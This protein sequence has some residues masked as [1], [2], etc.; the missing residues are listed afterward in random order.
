M[1]LE[2]RRLRAYHPVPMRNVEV[3]V[4]YTVVEIEKSNR[5]PPIIGEVMASRWL[6]GWRIRCVRTDGFTATLSTSDSWWQP[7]RRLGD[8]AVIHVDLTP[9]AS[10]E[11]R[12]EAW[13]DRR[14]EAQGS[15]YLHPRPRRHFILCRAAL[16]ALLC[17]RLDCRNDQLSFGAARFGKPYA[18]VSGVSAP[19]SFNVSHGGRH[20]L[21]ALAPGGRIGVDVEERD[22]RRDLEGIAERVFTPSEQAE[23][24]RVVGTE[25][26]RMFF[27]LWTMKEALIKAL[28]TGFHLSPSRLEVPPAMRHGGRSADFRFPQRRASAWRLENLGNADFAAAVA[29]EPSPQPE[30]PGAPTD[31]TPWEGMS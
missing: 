20:G 25:K 4:G 15:R 13:L 6:F 8:V 27:D 23:L 5:A 9:C 17:G 1:D 14:E 29:W 16:R 11:R 3:C 30:G 28:G 7:F 19:V 22:A 21:I 24:A 18:L 2:R 12:A 26:V 10:R 31:N